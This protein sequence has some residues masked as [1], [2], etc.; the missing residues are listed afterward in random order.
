MDEFVS[1]VQFGGGLTPLWV[2]TVWLGAAYL[3]ALG[4]T[5]FVRPR[6]AKKFLNGFASTS[7]MN[8]VEALLRL[9]MGIAF[10]GASS[11][12]KFPEFCVIFGIIL[13]MTAV[14]MFFMHRQHAKYADWAVPFAKPLLPIFGAFSLLLG[15]FVIYALI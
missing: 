15:G 6:L 7:R 11:A 14:P 8:R 1:G 2:L 5:I 3:L 9:L 12:T 10:I 4:I 13:V